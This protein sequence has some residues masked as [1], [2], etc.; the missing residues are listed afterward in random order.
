[1]GL[2]GFAKRRGAHGSDHV[3]EADRADL[4]RHFEILRDCEELVYTSANFETVL[5]RYDGLLDELSYIG[6]YEKMPLSN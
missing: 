4:A 6:A 5:R 2:F 1:M 3:L